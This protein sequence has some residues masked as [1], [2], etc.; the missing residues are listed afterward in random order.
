MAPGRANGL[1]V[2][3]VGEGVCSNCVG[4]SFRWG[5][6]REAPHDPQIRYMYFSGGRRGGAAQPQAEHLYHSHGYE[7]PHDGCWARY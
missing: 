6:T 2:V 3:V 5:A 7:G 4:P 1:Y